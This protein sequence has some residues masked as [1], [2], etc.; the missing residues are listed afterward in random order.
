MR[1]DLACFIESS[2]NLAC[3]IW[4]GGTSVGLKGVFG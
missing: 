3:I 4:D 2:T 1:S